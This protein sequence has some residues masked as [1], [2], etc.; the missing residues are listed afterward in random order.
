MAAINNKYQD[1]FTF[2]HL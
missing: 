1:T 2:L